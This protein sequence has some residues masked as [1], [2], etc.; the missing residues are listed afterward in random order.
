MLKPLSITHNH[1]EGK[2]SLWMGLRNAG[3]V[4]R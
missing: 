4:I 2:N 3:A 1:L